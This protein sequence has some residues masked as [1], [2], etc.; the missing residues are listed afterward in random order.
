MGAVR[1][2][3]LQK[4]A[5]ERESLWRNAKVKCRQRD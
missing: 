3:N 2:R 4:A 1:G 5:F